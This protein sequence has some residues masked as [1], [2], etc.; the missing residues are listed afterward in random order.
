MEKS[1]QGSLTSPTEL[2]CI[3]CGYDLRSLPTEESCPECGTPIELSLRG[4][5]LSQSDPA[6]VARLARGQSVLVFGVRFC[7]ICMVCAFAIPFLGFGLGFVF[8]FGFGIGMNIPS[9]V[10]DVVFW[11]FGGALFIGVDLRTPTTTFFQ[12]LAGLKPKMLSMSIS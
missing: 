12:L 9:W 1:D 11:S 7:L 2:R 5:L 8:A 4:D 10:F 6:W 3:T